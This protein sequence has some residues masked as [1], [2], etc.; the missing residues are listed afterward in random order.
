MSL[1]N[2]IKKLEQGQRSHGTLDKLSHMS[3]PHLS[4]SPTDFAAPIVSD[5]SSI[6]THP[7]R[8]SVSNIQSPFEGATAM[9]GPVEDDPKSRGFFGTSSAGS[10]MKQ[11]KAAIDSKTNSPGYDGTTPKTPDKVLLSS[12]MPEN[13]AASS[14]NRDYVLPSRKTADGLL[15]VYWSLVHPLYPFLHRAE[16][17]AIYH[18]LWTGEGKDDDMDLCLLNILLALSSQLKEDVKPNQR[19]ANA[20][21]FFL[22]AREFLY[23]DFWEGG[24]IRTVQCLLLMGQYLQ[25]TNDPQR[26]WMV[27]GLAVRLAQSLG[28][29]LEETLSRLQSIREQELVKKVWGGCVLMDRA[30][31]M[32]LGRPGMIS[33]ANAVGLPAPL[34]IDEEYLTD[35]MQPDEMQQKHSPSI[36]AFLEKSLPLYEIVNE[37]LVA[38]YNPLVKAR[39]KNSYDLYFGGPI[40]KPQGQ[41]NNNV[42]Q[43]E[44]ATVFQLDAALTEWTKSLPE[45]LHP[46]YTLIQENPTFLRQAN[47]I[48]AR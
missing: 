26:C 17:E 27:V 37:I 23:N 12:L 10:F 16:T 19:Q 14:R 20:N 5:T 30:V 28:L 35:E 11:V 48:W 24:S 4:Y 42:Y 9:M 44:N 41:S 15:G 1:G 18:K 13:K 43:L 25:S 38:I 47:I 22:R 45:H 39:N 32:T 3:N 33:R 36:M 46:S 8:S 40:I 21:V 29:H 7:T 31:C 2:R 34:C 6:L